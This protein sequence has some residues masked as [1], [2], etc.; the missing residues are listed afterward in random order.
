MI[1]SYMIDHCYIYRLYHNRYHHHLLHHLLLY[2]TS[3]K[4]QSIYRECIA[5][6]RGFHLPG[7]RSISN[8]YSYMYIRLQHLQCISSMYILYFASIS[9]SISHIV[10][11]SLAASTAAANIYH[12]Y[13]VYISFIFLLYNIIPGCA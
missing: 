5:I 11:A 1:T 8:I 7:K 4:S 3:T 12:I 13:S 6:L 9:I 10:L 2:L